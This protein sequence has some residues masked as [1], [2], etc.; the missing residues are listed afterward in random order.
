MMTR[1]PSISNT[2]RDPR[3]ESSGKKHSFCVWISTSNQINKKKSFFTLIKR[4]LFQKMISRMKSKRSETGNK[5]RSTCPVET[6]WQT[7]P[8]LSPQ[9]NVHLMSHPDSDNKPHSDHRIIKGSIF[10]LLQSY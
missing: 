2:G 5:A 6:Y 10:M 3:T 8:Y 7:T 9:V 4:S 1:D